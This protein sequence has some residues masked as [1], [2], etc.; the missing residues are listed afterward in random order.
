MASALELA[1][2]IK[3]ENTER[4]EA[5]VSNPKALETLTLDQFISS[6]LIVEV[7]SELFKDTVFLCSGEGQVKALLEENPDAIYFLGTELKDLFWIYGK[8]GKKIFKI[9]Y[10][11][12]SVW[13]GS[14][15]DLTKVVKVNPDPKNKGKKP[16]KDELMGA[17]VMD[18]LET[19]IKT[20]SQDPN[21]W[22]KD[23]IGKEIK[24]KYK[25]LAK[26]QGSLDT[27][28]KKQNERP[29]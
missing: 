5:V 10:N 16:G 18:L 12:K 15:K 21:T 2:L 4:K 27:K 19:E 26:T 20:I 28:E 25:R 29:L 14:P 24:G 22:T 23:K 7:Y 1:K 13:K 17:G 3:K 8:P 6:S 11:L 9:V